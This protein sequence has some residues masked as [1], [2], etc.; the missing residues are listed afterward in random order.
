M[1]KRLPHQ[2]NLAPE[3]QRGYLK[4]IVSLDVTKFLRKRC[5]RVKMWSIRKLRC[6]IKKMY[7]VVSPTKKPKNAGCDDRCGNRCGNIGTIDGCAS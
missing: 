6:I 7:D 5:R 1:A 3:E 4:V 2:L